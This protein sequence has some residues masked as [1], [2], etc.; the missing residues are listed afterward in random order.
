M[1][2]EYQNQGYIVLLV[3][4][5]RKMHGL[6]ANIP[7]HCQR[8]DKRNCHFLSW[9]QPLDKKW[10]DFDI[11]ICLY[12]SMPSPVIFAALQFVLWTKHWVSVHQN[13]WWM[14]SFLSDRK[15]RN[16]RFYDG[17]N[18]NL[19]S[20]FIT[21]KFNDLQQSLIVY[22]TKNLILLVAPL[23]SHCSLYKLLYKQH[24]K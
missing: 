12:F 9:E 19:I 2:N 8:N 24:N 5:D 13:F 3:Q 15:V 14:W 1:F 7:N 16:F 4:C 21:A 20:L 17:P 23:K 22:C 18:S 11:E 6:V 10:L